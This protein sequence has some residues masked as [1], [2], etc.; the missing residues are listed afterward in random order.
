M[1]DLESSSFLSSISVWLVDLLLEGTLI[2]WGVSK[3][4]G[5]A[6]VDKIK[7]YKYIIPN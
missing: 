3:V 1:F 2:G 6:S 7:L 5:L 4:S